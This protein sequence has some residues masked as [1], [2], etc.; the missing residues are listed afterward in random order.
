MAS[1]RTKE[2]DMLDAI[3]FKHYGQSAG[4]VELVFNA[5]PG[6]AAKGSRFVSGIVIELPDIKPAAVRQEVR[7]WD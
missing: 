5:N 4:M 1:Y 6:L 2:G 3:C 7:L